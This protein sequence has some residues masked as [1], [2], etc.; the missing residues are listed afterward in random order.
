MSV[1]TAKQ[2]VTD[3]LHEAMPSSCVH[4]SRTSH[5]TKNY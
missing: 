1:T 2:T 4:I 5:K 3:R